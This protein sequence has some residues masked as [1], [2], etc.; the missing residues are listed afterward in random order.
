MVPSIGIWCKFV[1]AVLSFVFNNNIFV[2]VIYRL[3]QNN[4]MYTFFEKKKPFMTDIISIFKV[5]LLLN[6]SENRP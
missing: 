1:I 2:N 5:I 6:Y 4:Y 3:K